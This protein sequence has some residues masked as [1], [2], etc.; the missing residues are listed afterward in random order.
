MTA[1]GAMPPPTPF[2]MASTLTALLRPGEVVD[3]DPAEA[4]ADAQPWTLREIYE[5]HWGFVWRA[6]RA[7]GV[8]EADLED[9]T[10]EVFLVVHR[11]LAGFEGRSSLTTWLWGIAARV[12]SDWRRRAHIRREQ[13]TAAPPEPAPRP[14]QSP[15]TQAAEAQARA[16]L[17]WILDGM[18]DEQRV[19]FALFELD[20]VAADDIAALVGCP[21]NTVHSRLRLARRHFE[22]A[23]AR[24]HAREAR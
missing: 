9:Q 4:R 16:T 13:I 8:R 6:L 12:A 17:A 10:H 21:L 24:V 19:V 15:D 20:G 23:L 14:E 2:A 18:P 22:K 11:K 7:H 1:A 3:L 5:A